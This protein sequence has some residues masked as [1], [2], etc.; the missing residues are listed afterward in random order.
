MV[1][2]YVQNNGQQ[3]TSSNY[4]GSD[5][6]RAGALYVSPN[7]GAIRLLLPKGWESSID[8]MRTAKH[9]IVSRGPHESGIDATEFLFDDLTDDPYVITLDARQ[10]QHLPTADNAGQTWACTVWTPPRRGKPHCALTRPCYYRIVPQLPWL[11]PLER[12]NADR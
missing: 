7:A 4:W 11:K 8:E 1:T 5:L 6:D 2:I 10:W 3:I 9:V 12:P